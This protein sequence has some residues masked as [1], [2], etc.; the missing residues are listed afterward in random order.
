MNIFWAIVLLT[1]GLTILVKGA[2]LLING[3]VALAERLGVS[4]LIIGLTI[5][6]MG[7]SAPEVAT[8]ITFA[9]H[10]LGNSAIGNVYGSNIANLALV[11]GICAM[12][13]PIRVRLS[14]VRRELP[15]MLIVVLLLLPI[16]SNLHLS[17]IEGASLLGLFGVLLA[18]TVFI[19]LRE[20]RAKPDEVAEAREHIGE[21]VRHPEKPAWYSLVLI[22]IGLG[23]LALGA[24]LAIRGGVFIGEKIGLSKTVIGLTILAVGTSLPELMTCVVAAIKGHDDLSVG[25]LVGSNIFNALLAIGCAGLIRPFDVEPRLVGIDYLVVVIIST[26]FMLTA[27]IYNRI[28]RKIGLTLALSYV[29]YIVYL[30]AVTPN[31]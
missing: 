7:T 20:S 12:I 18:L 23:G 30:L 24:D 3:A 6:S 11:G 1:A 9:A 4:P 2:D 21:K 29:A 10:S 26:A 25:T 17:R 8:S 22:L 16:L 28:D 14:V 13:R 19:G 15:V 31:A 5:V 27:M